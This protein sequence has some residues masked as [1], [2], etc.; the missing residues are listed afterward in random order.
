[1][2]A[3]VY[4][5]KFNAGEFPSAEWTDEDEAELVRLESGDIGHLDRSSL[6]M[7]A[8]EREEESLS[9]RLNNLPRERITNILLSINLTVLEEVIDRLQN[10][11]AGDEQE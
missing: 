3:L 6:M 9:T 4:R 5:D 8:F 1:M 10:D 2:F 7:R 11:G